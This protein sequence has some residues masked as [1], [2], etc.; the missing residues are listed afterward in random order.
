VSDAVVHVIQIT[1]P[2]LALLEL[3]RAEP[4][5]VENLRRAS[6]AEPNERGMHERLRRHLIRAVGAQRG[7]RARTPRAD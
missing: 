4:I 7:T 5:L 3:I 6:Y 1:G 2:E